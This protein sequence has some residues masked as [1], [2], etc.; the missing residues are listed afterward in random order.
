M[1]LSSLDYVERA[2]F[3]IYGNGKATW[4][5]MRLDGYDAQGNPLYT[6]LPAAKLYEILGPVLLDEALAVTT[7]SPASLDEE[8]YSLRAG[9]FRSADGTSLT[10]VLVN[11]D[12][13]SH[14][15]ELSGLDGFTPIGA[16]LLTAAGPLAETIDIGAISAGPNSAYTLPGLSVAIVQFQAVPEPTTSLL[17]FISAL[18]LIAYSRCHWPATHGRRS[19]VRL[20]RLRTA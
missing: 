1:M 19:V 20:H 6:V 14:D 3:F 16:Q 18:T 12:S 17:V 11:R 7:T 4:H 15:A 5:P 13:V 10:L 2:H 8:T 9:A